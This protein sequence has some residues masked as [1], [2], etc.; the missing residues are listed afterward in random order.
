MFDSPATSEN[1]FWNLA[2][3]NGATGTFNT[4][5]RCNLYGSLTGSGTLNF[6]ATSTNTSL[7]GD[8]SPF[9]GKINVNGGEF[10]VLNL[11]GYPNTAIALANNVTADFQGT[12]DPNGTTLAIGELSGASSSQLI[13]GSATNGE[14]LTWSIGGNNTD[15]TFAGEIREQNTNA[16]TAI[17]KIGTGKWTLTGSNSYNGGTLISAGTL[18]VNNTSGSGTGYGDVEVATGATLSGTGTIAGS[19]IVDANGTFAPNNPSG[20]LS[21][22]G[23]L[24]LDTTANLQFTLGA[25]SSSAN[26]AGNLALAGNLSVTAGPGFAP[27]T[28]TLFNYSGALNLSGLTI[29]SAPAS[30]N[31]TI[32]TSTAGKIQL[33]VSG[34]QFTHTTV[35]SG[36]LILSGSGGPTNGTYY[37]LGSTNLALPLNQWPPIATNHFDATGNF[38]FTNALDS[39]TPHEYYLLEL[40]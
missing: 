11:T 29:A 40:P 12:V 39:L 5:S 9:T 23:D 33:I 24:N 10:R 22:G 38:L 8:W 17:Q 31:Y 15:A 13:G 7:Y 3:S 35:T 25:S 27:G 37:I 19:V 26:V 34:L 18:I 20:I 32:S 21:I 14:V 4:D 30:Y 6:N 16:N 1:V 36:Q 28:Y 2:V